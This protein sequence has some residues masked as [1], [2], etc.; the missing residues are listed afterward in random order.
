MKTLFIALRAAIF[1]TGFI[2][3]WGWVALK[4]PPQTREMRNRDGRA[5]CPYMVM[6]M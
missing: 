3:L 4:P 2:F 1:G 5:I 6:H